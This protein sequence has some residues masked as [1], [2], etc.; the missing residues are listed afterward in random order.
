MNWPD[1]VTIT[2]GSPAT[3]LGVVNIT[4]PPGSTNLVVD[5]SNDGLAHNFVLTGD[6]TTSTLHDFASVPN[7]SAP[8]CTK[9]ATSRAS[10][11]SQANPTEAAASHT[12]PA[13]PRAW[14]T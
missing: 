11:F 6:G 14:R 3:V 7:A 13:A 8:A 10:T 2:S 5:L 9:K 1:T 4:E 12:P